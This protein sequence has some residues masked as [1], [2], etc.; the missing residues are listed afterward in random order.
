[1]RHPYFSW[2]VWILVS[3]SGGDGDPGDV[4]AVDT[5]TADTAWS[6]TG[7]STPEPVAP[8]PWA[9][10]CAA[11]SA[12]RDVT[13][14]GKGVSVTTEHFVLYLEGEPAERAEAYGQLAEAA[15]LA[16]AE[17]HDGAE[18]PQ[19]PLDVRVYASQTAWQEGMQAE[20][21]TVPASA[22]GYYD[23]GTQIASLFQQPTVYYSQ[24]LFLHEVFHQ[25]HALARREGRPRPA[26]EGE[27]ER[28][29][30]RRPS[31]HS[32]IFTP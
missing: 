9:Q 32:G 1:M 19:G 5:G 6:D 2:I 15:W 16:L 30:P 4:G 23:P 11:A 10:H 22:G 27:G 25:F 17:I 7:V 13:S 29:S 21:V 26:G 12:V 28:A 8:H 14:S 20:G 3:C 18:P 24:T 31:F